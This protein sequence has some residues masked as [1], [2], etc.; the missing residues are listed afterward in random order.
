MAT[1]LFSIFL[2]GTYALLQRGLYG[3]LQ[4]SIA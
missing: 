4:K 1:I 3:K 2:F